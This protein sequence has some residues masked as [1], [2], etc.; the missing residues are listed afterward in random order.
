MNYIIGIKPDRTVEKK[1]AIEKEGS[2]YETIHEIIGNTICHVNTIRGKFAE[3]QEQVDLNIW[4]DDEFLLNGSKP[5]VLATTF[6]DAFIYGNVAIDVALPFGESRGLTEQ[7]ANA[8][9]NHLE[10]I[11]RNYD[12]DNAEKYLAES[13]PEPMMKTSEETENER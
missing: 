1:E 2:T 3:T 8:I 11:A 4:A 7:E 5:N 12:L 9:I 13:K 6:G 10:S